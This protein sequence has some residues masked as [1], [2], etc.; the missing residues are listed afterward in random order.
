MVFLFFFFKSFISSKNVF[1][2]VV[3]IF[4]GGIGK[5]VSIFLSIY[6]L[7]RCSFVLVYDFNFWNEFFYFII[8]F[9]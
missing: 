3:Y 8:I 4:L 2:V 9:R 5:Y 7:G 6:I 1:G